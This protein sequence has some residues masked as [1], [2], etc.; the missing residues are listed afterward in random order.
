MQLTNV[1]EFEASPRMALPPPV[2]M[3]KVNLAGLLG[4]LEERLVR[5]QAQLATW[6]REEVTAAVARA[7]DA[8]AGQ[9]ASQLGLQEARAAVRAEERHQVLGPPS[10]SSTRNPTE[11]F[12]L[13]FL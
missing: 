10:S 12:F 2:R 3:M 8:L 11:Y 9:L 4:G 1:A 7:Q 13:I 6:C 5:Q